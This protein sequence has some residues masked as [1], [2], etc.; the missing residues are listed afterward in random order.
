MGALKSNF[1]HLLCII[2]FQSKNFKNLLKEYI[3]TGFKLKEDE[4]KE[5]AIQS[6]VLEIAEDYLSVEFRTE[7]ERT[8]EIKDVNPKD[9][10]NAFI[11]LKRNFNPSNI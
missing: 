3:F 7:Y 1:L 2:I 9:S 4:L 5:A 8:I 10:K 6:G 11:Y